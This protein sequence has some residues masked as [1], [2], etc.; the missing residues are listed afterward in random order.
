MTVKIRVRP[1]TW[2]DRYGHHYEGVAIWNRQHFVSIPWHRVLK[3]AD[4]LVDTYETHN[5]NS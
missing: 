2:T 4:A 1:H 3:I 5:T